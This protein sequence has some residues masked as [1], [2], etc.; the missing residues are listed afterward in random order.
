MD[1]YRSVEELTREELDELKETY[2]W[3]V[4]NE[5]DAEEVFGDDIEFP[6]DIPDEVVMEHFSHICFVED[7]FFCN[8]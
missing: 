2:F 3:E 5:G 6:W 7:D 4:V 1:E 8:C